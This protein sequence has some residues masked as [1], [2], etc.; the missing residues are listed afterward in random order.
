[1]TIVFVIDCYGIPKNG[2]TS[3]AR[4]FAQALRE[5]G[6][7]VKILG[8]D[9]LSGPKIDD[10][11]FYPVKP[12]HF[13]LFQGLIE[14]DG[15]CYA[16]KDIEKMT[17]VIKGADVVHVFF[18]FPFESIARQIAESLNIPVTSAFHLQPNSVTAPLHL[19]RSHFVNHL[20]YRAF[21]HDM[22]RYTSHVHC[23]STMIANVLK[24]KEGYKNCTPYVISNGVIDYFHPIT[25]ERPK[26]LQGKF[27]VL[28]VGR[29]A[30]EKKQDLI[31]KAIGRSKHNS[32]IQL[33]LSGDGPSASHYVKL[34][35]KYLK[36]PV[37]IGFNNQENLR[38]IIC[39]SDL[40]V[41]A[42]V[43]EIEGVA[44]TEAFSCGLVPVI[45]DSKLSAT[46]QFALDPHCLFKHNDIS[47]LTRKI[48]YF[49]EHPQ[50]KEELSKKYI[51]YSKDFALAK[52]TAAFEQ[53]LLD[54]IQ[55]KKD[56]KDIFDTKPGLK[57]K[58]RVKRMT[59]K[60]QKYL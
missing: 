20:L 33:I 7:R 15:F 47:D 21:Y 51:A 60:I 3:S 35:R 37:I 2:T 22:Y 57:E 45:S 43:T 44:C 13:P 19:G 4:R 54:A 27:V 41:H 31:I 25:A 36:N 50:E 42:S 46:N 48:D 30:P 55:E 59:K 39:C 32:N 28:M 18:S 5:K 53:F 12:F 6:H 10:P 40:Y 34:G 9:S 23:P 49:F 17:E 29:L 58:R 11:D 8:V 16:T 56:K 26:N 38:N 52:E 14:K 24:E 1:M